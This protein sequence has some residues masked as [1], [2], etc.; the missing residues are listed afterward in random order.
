MFDVGHDP[1]ASFLGLRVAEVIF[2]FLNTISYRSCRASK[3]AKDGI[4]FFFDARDL[5]QSDLMNLIRTEARGGIP[6]QKNQVSYNTKPCAAKCDE[7]AVC[8]GPPIETDTKTV[9]GENAVHLSKGRFEPGVI[10]V[11]YDA[12]AGPV[13]VVCEVGRVS[14]DKIDALLG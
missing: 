12:P 1:F 2:E 14:Q 9:A 6:L 5:L 13:C 11:V 4:H 8:M 3:P 10:I 7:K